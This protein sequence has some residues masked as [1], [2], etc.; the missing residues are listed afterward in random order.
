MRK[1]K[2]Q[3]CHFLFLD[4]VHEFVSYSGF[5]FFLAFLPIANAF[6]GGGVYFQLS[7]RRA[8]NKFL[9]LPFCE[10]C[11]HKTQKMK[12][13]II[14]ACSIKTLRLAF[15][16]FVL[17]FQCLRLHPPPFAPRPRCRQRIWLANKRFSDWLRNKTK[18]DAFSKNENRCDKSTRHPPLHLNPPNQMQAPHS[19]APPAPKSLPAPQQAQSQALPKKKPHSPLCL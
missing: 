5:R 16:L 19:K 10:P 1:T 17:V 2:P 9:H 3:R 14:D 4:W 11:C 7:K 18:N 8:T 12:S 15:L 6:V 13:N